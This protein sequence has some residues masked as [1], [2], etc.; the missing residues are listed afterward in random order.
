MNTSER[1]D[2]TED[3]LR[4]EFGFKGIVMTDWVIGGGML[5]KG[6]KYPAPNAGK[7]AAAGSDL[8]MPGSSKDY[9]EVLEALQNG[10]LTRQQLEISA[11]RVYRMAM[12]LVGRN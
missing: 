2:L 5:S 10:T 7:T 6:R 8:F 9:Q 3:I 12:R 4:S 1:R 11:S